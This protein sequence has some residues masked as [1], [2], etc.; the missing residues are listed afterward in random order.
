M[1]C[2]CPFKCLK[3]I[4]TGINLLINGIKRGFVIRALLLFYTQK[5]VINIEVIKARYKF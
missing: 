5:S 4:L 3:F 2:S 1:D